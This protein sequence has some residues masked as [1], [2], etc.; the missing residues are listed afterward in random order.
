M[1]PL[2]INVFNWISK[3]MEMFLYPWKGFYSSSLS[4]IDAKLINFG[5]DTVIYMPN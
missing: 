2:H 4:D 5:Y 1:S 3:L